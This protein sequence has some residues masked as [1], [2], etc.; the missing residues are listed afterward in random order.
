MNRSRGE[1]GA[2]VVFTAFLLMFMMAFVA[3]AVDFGIY[4]RHSSRLQSAADAAALA[5]ISKYA[6]DLGSRSTA[7]LVKLPTFKKDDTSRFEVTIGDKQYTFTRLTSVPAAVSE[8]ATDYKK[9]D[10]DGSGADMDDSLWQWTSEP[11]VTQTES[12]ATKITTT[13]TDERCAYRVI[14][15]DTVDTVFARIFG[16]N[17]LPL[18]VSAMAMLKGQDVDVVEELLPKISGNLNDIIPNYYWET[19]VEKD[20][21][22]TVTDSEHIDAA[23]GEIV[24][25]T[26]YKTRYYGPNNRYYLTS[27]EQVETS[28][29][30][31]GWPKSFQDATGGRII[32]F[33]DS[34]DG[35]CADPIRADPSVTDNELKKR[36]KTLQ[37]NIEDGFI[38]Q[39]GEDIIGL[40]LDRDNVANSGAGTWAGGRQRFTELNIGNTR[41]NN[42]N[43][44]IYIRIESEP[45]QIGSNGLTTVH[46]V[47]INVTGTQ[48]KPVVLAYD[49]PD[50]N[51]VETD[52][53]SLPIL[54]TI[55]KAWNQTLKEPPVPYNGFVLYNNG[56][57]VERKYVQTFNTDKNGNIVPI[58]AGRI[59]YEIEPLRKR[60]VPDDADLSTYDPDAIKVPPATMV[61]SSTKT[62]GPVYLNIPAGTTFNGAIY[63]PRSKI[64]IRGGGMINGFVAARR[65]ELDGSFSNMVFITSQPIS[66]P[67]LAA[68]RRNHS[69]DVNVKVF[70][71][72][73]I[74]EEDNYNMVYSSFVD[75]TDSKYMPNIT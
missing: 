75:Y 42:P 55:L 49:G 8:F 31:E 69:T 71:Y 68:Y 54:P 40:F 10:S 51:R 38:Q 32:G 17:T 74:Y 24:P 61:L 56:N 15:S 73:K 6:E 43:V 13:T 57:K 26:T 19:I 52:A 65:I 16:V 36:V 18:N 3:F 66:I 27:A 35:I 58:E 21:T 23:T 37:Y 45:I 59:M 29:S 7:R 70:D 47:E 34:A 28:P 9:A 62:P 64:V 46:G 72:T 53:P 48:E 1:R 5:G 67:T 25:E 20:K 30:Y 22:G 63:M 33:K 44:P 11:E 12:G 39:N 50:P 14:L 4:Y 60:Y 41:G 2:F